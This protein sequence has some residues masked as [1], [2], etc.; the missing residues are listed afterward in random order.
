MELYLEQLVSQNLNLCCTVAS[1]G[2]SLRKYRIDTLGAIKSSLKAAF[3]SASRSVLTSVAL[4]RGEI[5]QTKSRC[6]VKLLCGA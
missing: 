3:A 4:R 1:L 5:N 6:F 2:I